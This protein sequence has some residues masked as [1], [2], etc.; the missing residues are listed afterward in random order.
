MKKMMCV[1]LAVVLCVALAA[2]AFAAEVNFV[3][4]ISFK[5]APAVVSAMLNGKD[6]ASCLVV[7]SI[8][9]A[10]NKSTDI[11]QDARDLLLDVYAKLSAGT[12]T[13]PVDGEHVVRDLVD[14]NFAK[15]ACV[16][17]GHGHDTELAADG[18]TITVT[19]DL[20]IT[21]ADDIVV[22]QYTDGAWTE[23]ESENN[24]DGTMTCEFEH[25]CP[26]AFVSVEDTDNTDS[27]DATEGTESTDATESTG[28]GSS[29]PQS[30]DGMNLGL[31]IGILVASAAVLV[32]GIANRRKIF[33]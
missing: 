21:S 16:D 3:P 18:T 13:L 9:A 5:D 24:G 12:M 29:T 17:A 14:V 10:E 2:P 7:T 8:L 30:G 20:G 23:V 26:V 31:W 6:V 27:T 28:N 22:L 19:F 15:T 25:F 4:S 11:T 33:G 32:V 1:I